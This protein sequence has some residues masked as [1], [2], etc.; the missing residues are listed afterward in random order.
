MNVEAEI[1]RR[2]LELEAIP[3]AEFMELALFWPQGGYYRGSDPIGAQ[4]DYYTSSQVHPAF[5][6][7]LAVQLFQMWQLLGQPEP[8]TVA[9]MGAGNGLLCREIAA[10]S[11]HLPPSFARSL[12]YVCLDLRASVGFERNVPGIDRIGGLAR[13]TAS[14]IP[15]RD[16]RGCVLSNEFLDALPVHQVVCQQG[17]L[18]E[19]FVTLKDGELATE[20]GEPSTPKLAARLQ[21]LGVELTEGQTAEVNLELDGWAEQVAAALKAGFVLTIDYGHP[22]AELYSPDRRH[23]GTLTTFYHH[24]QTDAPFRHVG[25]QDMTAQVDFTSVVEAGRRRGLEPLGFIPQGQFLASLGLQ[26][27]ERRLASLGLPQRVTQAN[28]AGMLDLVRPGGLGDFKVLVQGKGVGEAQLWGFQPS[29]AASALVSEL[30]VPLLTED[31]L[32]LLEGRYPRA[33]IDFEEL[34]PEQD[35]A[36]E[37]SGL[38]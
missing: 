32:Q 23:R 6:A 38:N 24:T 27:L 10:Y 29:A 26:D 11:L 1:H 35:E 25:K 33:E 4:G 21:D 18:R 20:L 15:L 3:F 36:G 16:V 2:I 13:V 19:V 22:A 17:K 37:Q 8:F 9:E 7:L 34:W 14:G 30:P 31:N 5:G 28:R 12:R